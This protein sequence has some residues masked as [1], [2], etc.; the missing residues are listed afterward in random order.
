MSAESYKKGA[1]TL[2]VECA[3][4]VEKIYSCVFAGALHGVE[5]PFCLVTTRCG[6]HCHQVS[7]LVGAEQNTNSWLLHTGQELRSPGSS[8]LHRRYRWLWERV[9]PSSI[10]TEPLLT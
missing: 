7:D 6:Q 8:V 2:R 4:A 1:V 10:K 5:F 3:Y 9:S